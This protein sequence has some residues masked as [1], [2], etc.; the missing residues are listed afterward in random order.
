M[1]DILLL[2]FFIILLAIIIIIFRTISIPSKQIGLIEKPELSI[3]RISIAGHL[4][5]ALKFKTISSENANEF[6]YNEF[7]EFH[8]FLEKTYPNIHSKLKKTVIGDY[9]L[10][11]EWK[12]RLPDKKAFILM[13][14]TDVVPVSA[15][16]EKEWR[17]PAFSGE[18]AEGFIWGR[19]ATDCKSNVIGLCEAVEYLLNTGFQPEGTIYLAF[20]HDEEVMGYQGARQ[21]AA[22]LK[23]NGVEADAILDEGGAVI[24]GA[25]AGLEKAVALVGNSEKGF[26]NLE[27]MVRT[28]GGHSSTPPKETAIGILSKAVS[29]VEQH[30]FRSSL[31]GS[32]GQMLLFVAKDMKPV[33]R[34]LFSNLWLFRWL[35]KRFMLSSPATAASVRSTA[36]VTMIQ[37]GFKVNVLPDCARAVINIRTLPGDRI[38]DLVKHIK[39]VIRDER[40]EIKQIGIKSEILSTSDTNTKCFQAIQKTIRQVFPEAVTAPYQVLGAT[41]SRHYMDISDNIYR[42]GPLD[43]KIKDLEMN[44]G[45]NERV[46]MD[47]FKKY[48]EFYILFI[49]NIQE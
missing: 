49:Q 45:V 38:E 27:L 25:L 31:R 1:V 22:Y 23:R 14:H 26:I 6:H 18:I 5:E 47:N 34:L 7:T 41:D 2:L 32:V 21:I 16:T 3:D 33:F 43:I 44:H 8:T 30:P 12:G 46:S 15:D 13:A 48:V 10:L 39:S 40:V 11:F 42:F 36:A 29:K 4:S 17:Y 9:S 20:G 35:I 24:T 19:G 28:E 37:G